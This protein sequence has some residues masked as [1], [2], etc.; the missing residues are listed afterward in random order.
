[1]Q[2]NQLGHLGNDGTTP[3]IQMHSPNVYSFPPPSV[4]LAFEDEIVDT[5]KQA[6][7]KVMGDDVDP[8]DFMIFDDR[9]GASD[10]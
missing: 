3:D 6:W 5:V 8:D 9:D 10:E 1:M 4:D 2:Y 7:L